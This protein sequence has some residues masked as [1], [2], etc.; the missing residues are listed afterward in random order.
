MERWTI[1]G[2]GVAVC[3]DGEDVSVGGC[4]GKG[5]SIKK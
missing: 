4:I 5:I 2:D 3:G 1:V